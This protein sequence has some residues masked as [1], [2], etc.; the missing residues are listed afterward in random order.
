MPL[1]F[2]HERL[3]MKMCED[4][5]RERKQTDGVRENVHQT[6]TKLEKELIELKNWVFDQFLHHCLGSFFM[7]GLKATHPMELCRTGEYKKSLVQLADDH[8]LEFVVG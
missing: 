6:Q 3:A 2:E 5:A 8:Y 7:S 4:G 1:I